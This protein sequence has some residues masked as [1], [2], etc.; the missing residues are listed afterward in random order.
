[1][2][3]LVRWRNFQKKQCMYIIDIFLKTPFLI[4]FNSFQNW[5]HKLA[6]RLICESSLYAGVYGDSK[7]QHDAWLHDYH[8]PKTFKPG[9]GCLL[10][11]WNAYSWY[12]IWITSENIFK[13]LF[14]NI[15]SIVATLVHI[16]YFSFRLNYVFVNSLTRQSV[17]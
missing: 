15:S 13:D 2:R 16:L 4:C 10:Y 9:D 1:M 8:P 14:I 3:G 17:I 12:T 11:W 7:I 6:V 5:V